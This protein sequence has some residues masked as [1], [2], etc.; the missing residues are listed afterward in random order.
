[1]ARLICSSGSDAEESGD[2][3]PDQTSP[4]DGGR[5]AT[6]FG[7]NTKILLL[8]LIY[9]LLIIILNLTSCPVGPA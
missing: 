2:R 4:T 3:C 7:A 1:M 9:F 6:G 5:A 8:I